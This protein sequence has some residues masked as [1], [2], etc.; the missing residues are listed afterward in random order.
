MEVEPQVAHSLR[1]STA[2][3]SVACRRPEVRA[4]TRGHPARGRRSPIPLLPPTPIVLTP[5]A[6]PSGRHFCETAQH[7]VHG[8]ATGHKVK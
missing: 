4:R 5:V 7:D 2:A 3:R 6:P 8:D 1:F